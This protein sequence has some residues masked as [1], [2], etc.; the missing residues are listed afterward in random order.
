MQLLK[1]VGKLGRFSVIIFLLIV[2]SGYSERVD[3]LEARY[4]VTNVGE[5]VNITYPTTGYYNNKRIE[6]VTNT[7]TMIEHFQSEGWT[8]RGRVKFIWEYWELFTI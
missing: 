4:M 5:W 8:H 7:R 3:T 2:C 1:C 6:G